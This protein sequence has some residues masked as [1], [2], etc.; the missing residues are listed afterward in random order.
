MKKTTVTRQTNETDISLTLY[1]E[2]TGK[3]AIQTSLPLFDHFLEAAAFTGGFDLVLSV[4]GDLERDDHHTIEDTGIVLGQA[5]RKLAEACS[6]VRRYAHT[7]LPMDEAL[8]RTAL[9]LSGRSYLG[10]GLSPVRHRLGG[11]STENIREFFYGFCRESRS[12]LHIDQ[13]KGENDHHICEA[14][15]K[16]FGRVLKEALTP[17]YGRSTDSTKDFTGD[18]R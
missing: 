14:A 3:T 16:S 10:Y 17:V 6:P 5:V 12:T 13:L 15:F 4:R 11:I 7:I 18:K 1:C 2:S 8:I 9:D